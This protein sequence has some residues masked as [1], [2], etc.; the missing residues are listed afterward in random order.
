MEPQ[1]K[2]IKFLNPPPSGVLMLNVDG[3]FLN[4]QTLGGV[5]GVVRNNLGEFIAGFAY[6][7][8]HM[9]S[10]LHVEIMAIKNGIEL[11][12]AMEISVAIVH[13][14]CLLAV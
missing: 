14:D 5:G 11:L 7:K 10:P 9:V 13:S 4:H 12:Q 2:L 8:E 3:A 1:S 6:R